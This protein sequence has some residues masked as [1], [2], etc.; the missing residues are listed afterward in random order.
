MAEF[1]SI[2]YI[3]DLE[4]RLLDILLAAPLVLPSPRFSQQ[5]VYCIY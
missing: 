4:F 5:S 1:L 2:Y 3:L